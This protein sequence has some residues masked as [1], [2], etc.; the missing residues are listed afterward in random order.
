MKVEIRPLEKA[1]WHGKSGVDDFSQPKVIEALV[2]SVTNRYDTGLSEEETV[3]YSRLLGEN[4]SSEISL[5]GKPHPFYGMKK[6]QLKL[7]NRTIFLETE[8]PL[9]Y[10]K[11]KIAMASPFVANSM[12]EYELGLYPIATH[13]IYDEETEI[14]R[15]ASKIQLKNKANKISYELTL[16]E[17]IEIILVIR[18]KRVRGQSQDFIDVIVDDIITNSPEEFIRVAEMDKTEMHIRATVLEGL[19]K[20]VLTKE[21]TAVYYLGDIIG[22]D[23]EAAV[24]YFLDPNNQKQKIAIFEKINLV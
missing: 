23:Y 2:N 17:K 13:V 15:K 9:D 7:P 16:T 11:Y 5:D 10:V 22:F 4:L 14:T 19:N 12:R 24:K 8:I 18:N 20:N 1:K 3:K 21:G 6:G